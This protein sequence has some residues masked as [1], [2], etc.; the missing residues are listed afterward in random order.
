M[1]PMKKTVVSCVLIGLLSL[2][3]T[4]GAAPAP[5][6][7]ASI[8]TD[9]IGTAIGGTLVR[10]QIMAQYKEIN[11]TEE[12]R[13]ALFEKMKEKEGVVDDWSLNNRLDTIMGNVI[14][15]IRAVDPTVDKKPY[16]YFISPHDSKDINAYCTLGHNVNVY[17][18]IMA[19][20]P[21]DDELAVV[22]GHELGHGQ[23][24]HPLAGVKKSLNAAIVAG[25]ASAATGGIADGAIEQLYTYT[26]NVH[27][28]KP[29]EW[30][31]DNLS[32]EYITHTS[33]NPG[34]TAAVWQR[35]LDKYGDANI[36]WSDHPT[37]TQRRE[38]YVKKLN[39]WSGK[40]VT[41]KDGVVYVNGKEFV[42]P[43]A[44]DS[45]SS[46]ERSYFVLGNL[47]AVYH[48][49]KVAPEAYASGDTLMMGEQPIMTSTGSDPDAAALAEKLNKI[50]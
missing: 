44:T 35:F 46:K 47:A 22:L 23:K 34:A 33:Y 40:H 38:N 25:M 11:N 50:K 12:G 9:V 41:N 3:L 4:F 37:N 45:M 17:D 42:T 24:E 1:K 43:S 2:G 6:A 27:L 14:A 13:Q 19:F 21:N 36:H 29:M 7:E 10:D 28:S 18:S 30:E 31:A 32:F 5:K 8:L 39:K 15:G 16:N 48:N 26:Q 20:M 49:N